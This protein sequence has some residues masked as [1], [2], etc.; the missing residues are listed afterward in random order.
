MKRPVFYCK[1]IVQFCCF[2]C[3]GFHIKQFQDDSFD[4]DGDYDH[5][6]SIDPMHVSR[7]FNQLT[8]GYNSDGVHSGTVGWGTTLQAGGSRV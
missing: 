3:F 5:L 8:L 2:C 6:L 4:D 1:L 7:Y